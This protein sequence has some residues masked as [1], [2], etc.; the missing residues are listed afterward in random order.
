MKPFE[1]IAVT[2][3][4][5]CAGDF[6]QRIEAI[7]AS[8]VSALMLREK[9]L[10]EEDYE[11]LALQVFPLCGRRGVRFIAHQFSAVARR[12]G[13]GA[14][15]LPLPVFTKQTPEDL[16]G[17]S[18]GVSVHSVEEARY[19]A[20]RGAA[21]VVAGHVF[22]TASKEGLEGRGLGFLAEICRAV[23]LPVYAIGGISEDN[24]DAVR[25]TGAAGACLMSAF[26]RPPYSGCTNFFRAPFLLRKKPGFPL[27]S[28]GC[29]KRIYAAIPGAARPRGFRLFCTEKIGAPPIP[30][31]FPL[32]YDISMIRKLLI[33]AVSFILFSC[34][35][36]ESKMTLAADG[37]GT[38]ELVYTVSALARDW[39]AAD[40][41]NSP[42]PL[43]VGEADFYRSVAAA[44]GLTLNSYSRTETSESTVIKAVLGFASL[45]AL[46]GFVAGG[47]SAFSLRQEGGVNVFEQIITPGTTGGIDEKTKEFVDAFFKPYTLSFSLTTPRPVRRTVPPGTV[48]GAQASVSFSLPEL[49]ESADSLVW[50]VEW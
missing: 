20:S 8:G 49:I 16:A 29:A 33:A 27:Q 31:F 25:K 2:N 18:V 43:P 47:Q 10:S 45:E 19:A 50:R 5:A 26:M 21:C 28:F 24:I 4:L 35:S 22:Q 17:L 32:G 3:R 15:H 37:S 46:N 7:A 30:H 12:L 42:L 6:L 40:S 9:D 11:A 41:G 38:L 44:P 34:L 14:I 1:I 23:S 13:C 39:D 48:S 36:V